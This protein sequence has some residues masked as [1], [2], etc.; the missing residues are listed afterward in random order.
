MWIICNYCRGPLA[1]TIPNRRSLPLNPGL[2]AD[3]VPFLGDGYTEISPWE[4]LL[5]SWASEASHQCFRNP[6]TGSW[7][8]QELT[9]VL[10]SDYSSKHLQA[11][12]DEVTTNVEKRDLRGLGQRPT[13][14]NGLT[15]RIYFSSRMK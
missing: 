3:A 10:E 6:Q 9:Q 2:I 12:L 13:Y 4:G 1:T 7:Y 8:I 14:Q 11:M 5:I 15:D